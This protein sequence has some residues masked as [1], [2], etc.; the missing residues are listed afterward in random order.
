MVVGLDTPALLRTPLV[1]RDDGAGLGA[2]V[3]RFDADF[4]S[5]LHLFSLSS[6]AYPLQTLVLYTKM[7]QFAPQV[8]SFI[9]KREMPAGL[10][11]RDNLP[12]YHQS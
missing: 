9:S 5:D 1:L 3:F 8:P 10:L 11:V 2:V 4:G 12:P 7:R 6:G